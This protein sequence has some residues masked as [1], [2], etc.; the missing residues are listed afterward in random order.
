MFLLDFMELWSRQSDVWVVKRGSVSYLATFCPCSTFSFCPR[1]LK[2]HEVTFL[3]LFSSREKVVSEP[4]LHGNFYRSGAV[5]Y[6]SR[7]N[8]TTV[9]AFRVMGQKSFSTR[10]SAILWTKRFSPL[11]V[12]R[13]EMQKSLAFPSRFPSE[14]SLSIGEMWGI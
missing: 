1:T 5:L 10:G 12:D 14:R 8:W 2:W 3:I 4:S 7:S 13:F 6:G 9:N 11:M